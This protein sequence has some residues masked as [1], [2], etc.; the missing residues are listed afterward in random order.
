MVAY[1]ETGTAA[2]RVF[3]PAG[4]NENGRD[5][6]TAGIGAGIGTD[7]SGFGGVTGAK[8][9]CVEAGAKAGL[10]GGRSFSGFSI[11]ARIRAFSSGSSSGAGAADGSEAGATAPACVSGTLRMASW[12][13]RKMRSFT[14]VN[15]A[16]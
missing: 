3:V 1:E 14:S 7:C 15:K 6:E 5:G 4:E 12:I 10:G 8:V 2:S 16:G 9:V 13:G 11:S